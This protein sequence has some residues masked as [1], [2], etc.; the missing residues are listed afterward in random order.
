M[1]LRKRKSLQRKHRAMRSVQRA[2]ERKCWLT[3]EFQ[4]AR[5]L[6]RTTARPKGRLSSTPSSEKST[7]R[8]RR[9]ISLE[10]TASWRLLDMKRLERYGRSN[11]SSR[12][13]RF[14]Q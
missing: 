11:R 8:R 5:I 4:T 1:F 2:N 12:S 6:F 9:V 10:G 3:E 7:V 14:K 13:N